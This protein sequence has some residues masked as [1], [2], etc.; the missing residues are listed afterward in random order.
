VRNVLVV[1]GVLL[2]FGDLVFVGL[3]CKSS[4]GWL[5]NAQR[6]IFMLIECEINEHILHKK[7]VL[8]VAE[9]VDE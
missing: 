7:V 9:W 4:M 1:R 3:C 2:L 6:F 8:G 5:D